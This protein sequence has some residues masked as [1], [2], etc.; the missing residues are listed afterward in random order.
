MAGKNSHAKIDPA[1]FDTAGKTVLDSLLVEEI[2]DS[3]GQYAHAVIRSR[4]LPDARD[5]LKPVHRHILF[6]MEQANLWPT[7]SHVKSARIV[8]DCFAAGSLVHTPDGLRAIE[9]VEVDDEVLDVR[10]GS[11]RVTRTYA[12]RAAPMV[13]V[14]FDTNR[15]VLA[16]PDQLFRVVGAGYHTEWVAAKDLTGRLVVSM[17]SERPAVS[18]DA[19]DLLPYTLGLV[20][21]EG[22]KVDRSRDA[23]G[24]VRVEMVEEEPLSRAEAWAISE[25]LTVTR[26]KRDPQKPH[27]SAMIGLTFPR[28]QALL[29][30]ATCRSGQKRVPSAVLSDRGTWSSFLA[31]LYDGD[32]YVR[33]DRRE[34]VLSTTS[35]V[36]AQQVGAM[37]AD[38]G[39]RTGLWKE[40]KSEPG[41]ADELGVT[42]TGHDATKFARYLMRHV[43]IEY[44]K[45]AL[46]RL[47]EIDYPHTKQGGDQLPG[48][49]LFQALTDSH[50]GGGWFEGPAGE[51]FRM[52]MTGG[53]APVRYGANRYGTPL[54]ERTFSLG[55]AARDQWIDKL[56]RI[57]S[58]LAGP[59]RDLVGLSFTEVRMVEPA[60]D[61][62]NY[63]IQVDGDDHA[64]AVEGFDVHNCMG[65]YHPHGDSA[66]Y[67]AMVRL[68][69]PFSLN[70]PLVDGQGNFGSPNDPPAA[71]RY[72]EARLSPEALM[73]VDQLDEDTV[74]MV[75]NYDGELLK[76]DV[77]PCAFPNLIVNGGSGIA[78]GMAT[79]MIPHNLTE[80]IAAARL[81]I[82]DPDA[83]L[84]AIMR[85]LPGPD[86]PT[87]G[88]LIG[89][90]KVREAY[91]NGKASGAVRMRARVQVGPLEGSRGKQAIT[92]TELPYGV[93]TE[94][95]IAKIKE[96]IGKKQLQAVSDVKDLSEG[97][98]IR[99]VIEV[100]AGF[101]PQSLLVDLYRLT[102]MEQPFGINNMALL[103]GRPE[104]LGMKRL[105]EVFLAHRYDVVTRRTR[106][107]LRRAEARRHSVEGLLIA[108]DSIDKVIT[109]IRGSKDTAQ[110]KDRLVAELA[111]TR[112]K[113]GGKFV[114]RDL[115]AGQAQEILDMQLRRLVALEVNGLR[116][117]WDELTATMAALQR[118]LDDDTVLRSTVDDELAD[119]AV[120]LG[121][122]RRTTLMDGDL[123]EILA[124]ASVTAAPLEVKDDPCQVLLSSTGLVMRTAA[125]SEETPEG[126]RRRSV[127]VKHDTMAS[128]VHTT[129]RGQ[130]LVLTSGGRAFRAEVLPVPALPPGA[131]SVTLRGGM[132][133]SELVTGLRPGERV[134]GLSPVEPAPG[135][136]LGTK[137]G[138]VMVCKPE[139][140]KRED[141]WEMISL[142]DGDEVI[143]AVPLTDG[144]ETLVFMTNDAALLRFG[145]GKVRP[146]G[147]GSGGMAGVGLLAG[148]KVVFFG[149]VRTDDDAHGAPVVVTSTGG[150]VKVTP[151]G[152][153]PE[154]G[155]ATGGVRCHRFLKT[156]NQ[157]KVGWVGQRPVAATSQGDPVD[158]PDVDVRRDGSGAAVFGPDLIGHL[159]ERT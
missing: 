22:W 151:L 80:T 37:L 92:A 138:Q 120:R 67:D 143:G 6:A 54:R 75:P 125:E 8:G 142:K 141:D 25:G 36:L 98:D 64:F 9:D 4:A 150:S 133:A 3:Y 24:R 39:I 49:A 13:R 2:G 38:L 57:G 12:N 122:P 60:D 99:L 126:G 27:H 114:T 43:Q 10:G 155:R 46:V 34:I 129:A 70:T 30:A 31:G 29:D 81:L 18:S 19:L 76:P 71:S 63:D 111:G 107:R 110:A 94:A 50:R 96:C 40:S 123:K 153:Y 62:P 154:K 61:Q 91:E 104:L 109:I 26:Y 7:K 66:I 108:L 156:E 124:A 137:D 90:D 33:K 135:I 134:I 102:P 113:L 79:N 21:S 42:A 149:A 119:I 148:G 72:T 145:A 53:G 47:S 95:I 45:D 158:L 32:G 65:K 28:H 128:V 159:V 157:L 74:D 56:A 44:K 17:G 101:N 112:V 147:R 85:V 15:S 5:G 55:R 11:V 86:L 58:D 106:Y 68:A 152:E 51:R 1:A 69:Q 87:G 131:G 121:R 20:V 23:D 140:P 59:L 77:L 130:F 16:T 78:V 83:D 127:R 136:A 139:W 105:L 82:A 116:T 88:L 89:L 97:D 52:S 100:K 48:A 132:P 117:E 14:V 93:G 84:D 118:I 35:E 41:W 144:T 146:Q 103:D 115:D 73:L